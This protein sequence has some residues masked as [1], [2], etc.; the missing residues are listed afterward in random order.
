MFSGGSG[1]QPCPVPAHAGSHL[2][3]TWI[4][5]GHKSRKYSRWYRLR[6]IKSLRWFATM[7]PSYKYRTRFMQRAACWQL[8]DWWSH[9]TR[10]QRPRFCGHELA[11]TVQR[12][13]RG[14]L[15]RNVARRLRK[16]I[17]DAEDFRRFIVF[18]KSHRAASWGGHATLI[19]AVFRGWCGRRAVAILSMRREAQRCAVCCSASPTRHS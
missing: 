11:T 12:V 13:A 7:R 15:G 2:T 9:V 6:R 8:E 1:N 5:R 4:R 18:F 16:A 14:H 17:T 10:F 19:Q 3:C